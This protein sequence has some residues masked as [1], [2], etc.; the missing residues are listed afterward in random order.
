MRKF[1]TLFTMLI[2]AV[3]ATAATA[4]FIND[5]RHIK[6]DEL[7]AEAQSFVKKNFAKEKVSY[8]TADTEYSHTEYKVVFVSGTKIEFEDEGNWTEVDCRYSAVPQNL[9]PEA[10]ADY[11]QSNYSRSKIVELKR[12][13]NTWEAKLTGGLELTFDGNMRLID[14]DD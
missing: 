1:A 2:V 7:P 13:H 5:D 14:I 8:V 6:Y 4:L 11:V 12:E 9:V 3:A 10:I